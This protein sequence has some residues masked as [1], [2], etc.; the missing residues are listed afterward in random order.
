MKIKEYKYIFFSRKMW[1]EILV[2][3]LQFYVRY[4]LRFN[5]KNS[6]PTYLKVFTL[7]YKSL[8]YIVAYFFSFYFSQFLNSYFG[9]NSAHGA[10]YW[11]DLEIKTVNN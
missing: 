7:L 2:K 6:Q 10:T 5:A 1:Y 8:V 4:V 3:N 11:R 9:M